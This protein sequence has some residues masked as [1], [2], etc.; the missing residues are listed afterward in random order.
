MSNEQEN[1]PNQTNLWS[2]QSTQT[3]ASSMYVVKSNTDYKTV[4]LPQTAQSLVGKVGS[5]MDQKR[6][7]R[8]VSASYMQ[9]AVLHIE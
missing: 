1:Q 7:T 6:K 5:V 8:I 2:A 3:V 9:L 4:V